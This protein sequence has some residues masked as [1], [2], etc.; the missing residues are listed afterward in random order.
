MIQSATP[1]RCSTLPTAAGSGRVAI[2]YGRFCQSAQRSGIR[3]IV[4]IT[5]FLRAMDRS[6]RD[7]DYQITAQF[8]VMYGDLRAV[9]FVADQA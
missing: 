4:V 9:I 3:R 7:A 8:P 2:L 1:W 6:L 5:E